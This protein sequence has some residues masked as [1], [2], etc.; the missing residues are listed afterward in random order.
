MSGVKK[1]RTKITN[2]VWS[3]ET[4]NIWYCKISCKKYKEPHLADEGKQK[5]VRGSLCPPS[6]DLWQKLVLQT[7]QIHDLM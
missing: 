3:K 5:V 4:K 2:N 1:L 7:K 6:Q